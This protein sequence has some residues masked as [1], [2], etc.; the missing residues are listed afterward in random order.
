MGDAGCSIKS[1]EGAGGILAALDKECPALGP[2]LSHQLPGPALLT[3]LPTVM[4]DD[5]CHIKSTCV[6]RGSASSMLVCF[7]LNRRSELRGD[8]WHL[9][10]SNPPDTRRGEGGMN[11]KLPKWK[12][13][14]SSERVRA[15]ERTR[16]A[17]IGLIL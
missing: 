15:A 5:M 14:A 10:H 4:D 7:C 9:R 1:R 13:D 8:M 2:P 17:H 3:Q 16:L 6:H 11:W 12:V